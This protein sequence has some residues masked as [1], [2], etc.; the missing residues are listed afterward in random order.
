MIYCSRNSW[1]R[2]LSLHFFR[3]P[4]LFI[5]LIPLMDWT[6]R[7]RSKY[8]ALFA[9]TARKEQQGSRGGLASLP[10]QKFLVIPLFHPKRDYGSGLILRLLCDFL[11]FPDILS[12][13]L[14]SFFSRTSLLI[15]MYDQM[16][17]RLGIIHCRD[18]QQISEHL[19]DIPEMFPSSLTHN[20]PFPHFFLL[21]KN[22]CR[23][24]TVG[25]S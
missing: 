11:W 8:C 24:L 4:A 23:V 2:S 17:S 25:G 10:S 7:S 20:V 1:L 16:C 14:V 22:N 13:F 6:L 5:T 9:L 15:A 12:P 18:I 3:T 19:F 21:Q